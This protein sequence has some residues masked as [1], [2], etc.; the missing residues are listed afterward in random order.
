MKKSN[1]ETGM[2]V[3]LENGNKGIIVRDSIIY[4]NGGWDDIYSINDLSIKKVFKSRDRHTRGFASI[5][6]GIMLNLVW[7][8]TGKPPFS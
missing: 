4:E 1:L 6:D 3:E 7:I 2:V 5:G 8:V